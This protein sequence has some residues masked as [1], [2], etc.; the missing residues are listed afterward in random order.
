[1]GGLPRRRQRHRGPRRARRR[2]ARRRPRR[3]GPAPGPRPERGRRRHG[4]IAPPG[5][6]APAAAATLG[7]C[8]SRCRSTAQAG[9]HGG[10][11]A[12]LLSDVFVGPG[13][14]PLGAP[15]DW[16]DGVQSIA[17]GIA[18]N[19]SLETGLPVE[20]AELGIRAAREGPAYDPHRRHRRRRTPGPQPRP[21]A[22][23]GRSRARVARPRPLGRPRAR[24]RRAD[25]GGPL[26]RGCRGP[27][28][29]RGPRRRPHPPRRDRRAVQRARGRHHAHQRGPR[30][31][32]ARRR[33][34]G[35]HPEGHRGVEP[36]RARLRRPDRVGARP[37]PARRGDAAAPLERLR[38]CRSC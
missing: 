19:R 16:R 10:G 12:L 15:A 31:L 18:G 8:P 9:G 4:R 34:R 1:M 7:G 13:D 27:R 5:G 38:A 22:R 2:R 37:L 20:V 35:G 29:R 32:G 23:R 26:G 28:D 25:R 21:G 33:G 11:D 30:D 3:R 17:V 6:R 24:P 36:D 14:D